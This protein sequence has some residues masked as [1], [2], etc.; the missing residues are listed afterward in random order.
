MYE[1]VD[2]IETSVG[3]S[4][5]SEALNFNGQYFENEIPGYRTLYVSGRE[6][7]ETEITD[8]DTEISDGSRYRRKR[9]L[10][11][12]IVVGYQL[13]ADSCAAFR[14]AYNKLNALL[15]VEQA[16][17]I[18]LDEPDKYYIGT[19]VNAGDVPAGRNAITAE[20][21]F[22][23]A[24]PFKYSVEEKVISPS[25][26]NGKTFIVEYDG[27]YP[28]YPVLQA[29]IQSDLG[30]V[31]YLNE[32]AKIIQIGDV[33]EMDKALKDKSERLLEVN[34]SAFKESEW[35]K[36]NTTVVDA[37]SAWN[38]DGYMGIGTGTGRR[39]VEPMSYGSG[40]GWHGPGI[41]RAIPADSNGHSGARNFTFEFRNYIDGYNIDLGDAEFVLTAKDSN[42]KRCNLAGIAFWKTQ[43][44]LKGQVGVYSLG[45]LKKSIEVSFYNNTSLKYANHSIT[46]FDST[47]TF[48]VCGQK[49]EITDP[50]IKDM[51]AVEVGIC[52]AQWSNNKSFLNTVDWIRFT[53][54]SVAKWVDVP[55]KMAAGDVL[56]ADCKTAGITLNG[57]SHPEFGALGNEWEDFCLKPGVNQIQCQQSD[58]GKIP[59][60]KL[61]YREV[62]L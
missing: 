24:D 36:N 42:G 61:R 14:S 52:L 3:Q 22:Y 46:K 57:I 17:M 37:K 45:K 58:W 5:P 49:I 50:A 54:H 41:S 25:A 11:R 1:F 12:T 35:T 32:R 26:D 21:E 47:L 39:A 40:A 59:E 9:Y 4:L 15:D 19:K 20:I 30:F 16:K 34:F 31:S 44:G 51:E 10:P 56:L 38:Q 33:E 60:Y 23:C 8:L 7:I 2:T 13:I 18:F 27:T 28:A 6:M 48:Q 43:Y 55:N 62:F 53:S 29:T